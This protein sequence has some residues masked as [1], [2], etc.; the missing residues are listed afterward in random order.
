MIT[1][2]AVITVVVTLQKVATAVDRRLCPEPGDN[3]TLE[4]HFREL[5]VLTPLTVS[6]TTAAPA[7]LLSAFARHGLGARRDLHSPRAAGG[8]GTLTAMPRARPS[9]RWFWPR[10]PHWRT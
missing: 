9:R 1:V 8:T 4:E 2:K 7:L 3:A 10:R 6:L 5:G